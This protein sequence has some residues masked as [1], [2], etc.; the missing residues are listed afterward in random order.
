M[1]QVVATAVLTASLVGILSGAVVTQQEPR[2][3]ST[4][5]ALT[6]PSVEGIDG[7]AT[8]FAAAVRDLFASFLTG[9]GLKTVQL[10]SRLPSQAALEARE[11][12][13]REVLLAT[14]T[15]KRSNG[16]GFSS[17]VGRTAGMAAV[18]TPVGG[19]V[20]GAIASGATSAV[21]Q[22]I[23]GLASQ[24]KAKDEIELT[25]RLGA[26]DAVANATPVSSKAKAKVDGEDL[27]TGLVERAAATIVATA[28]AEGRR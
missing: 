20:A 2:P 23:Y 14:V 18:R 24:T 7:S 21:G 12:D 27:L 4:C 1:H 9:P 28:T 10:E 15:R 17:I 6:L 5:I 25:Y 19:G 3:S 22:A 8:S 11:K 16:N 13:C 26:P